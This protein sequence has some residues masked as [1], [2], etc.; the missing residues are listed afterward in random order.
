M[1]LQENLIQ[2]IKNV[3][4]TKKVL[5]DRFHYGREQDVIFCDITNV[6]VHIISGQSC[7]I[8]KG[9]LSIASTQEKLLY[10]WLHKKFELGEVKARKRFFISRVEDNINYKVNGDK[11]TKYS[12]DFT[13]IFREEFNAED[14]TIGE[15][16]VEN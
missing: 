2:D 12:V 13:Y 5:L 6:K 11:F 1:S 4:G 16:K 3:T 10:G 9:E 14:R 8:V 7:F 15:L